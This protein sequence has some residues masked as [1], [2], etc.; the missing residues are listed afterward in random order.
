[1]KNFLVFIVFW[2]FFTIA[3]MI[4]LPEMDFGLHLTVGGVA[5]FFAGILIQRL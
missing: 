1:M 2:L 5:G 3:S 4:T